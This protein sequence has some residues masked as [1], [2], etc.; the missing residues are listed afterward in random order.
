MSFKERNRYQAF[1]IGL[2]GLASPEDY[3]RL[4]SVFASL[5]QELGHC[6]TP[7]QIVCKFQDS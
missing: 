6:P 1:I 7:Y 3:F 4:G 5:E 2:L